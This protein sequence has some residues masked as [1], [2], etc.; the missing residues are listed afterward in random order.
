MVS[1][2]RN[3]EPIWANCKMPWFQIQKFWG[4]FW[5]SDPSGPEASFFV[6]LFMKSKEICEIYLMPIPFFMPAENLTL[7]VPSGNTA[8]GLR[9]V[10]DLDP[11]GHR[12]IDLRIRISFFQIIYLIILLIIF[13]TE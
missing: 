9:S 6:V 7:K 4:R 11:L 10:A 2:A 1:V 12:L 8:I 13:D 5:N 3:L